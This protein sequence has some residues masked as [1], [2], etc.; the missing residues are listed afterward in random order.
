MNE[1]KHFFI[2]ICLSHFI[3]ER[4]TLFVVSL[5]DRW[6]DIYSK[7]GLLLA[8]Y[9]LPGARGCQRLHHRAS[10][11]VRDNPNASVRLRITGSTLD[12]DWTDCLNLNAW[13]SYHVVSYRLHT[14]S[15]GQP[16][17]TAILLFTNHNVTACQSTRGH[18]EWTQNP[19]QLYSTFVTFDYVDYVFFFFF[20][21][22][23]LCIM[24]VIFGFSKV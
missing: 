16:R 15:T 10:R 19:C 12:S 22:H 5:R 13:L 18:Q 1:T 4:G 6:R 11:I 2:K 7:R 8:P 24:N 9:L 14:C 17:H 23:C 3:L 20:A 21:F